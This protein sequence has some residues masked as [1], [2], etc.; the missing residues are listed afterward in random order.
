MSLEQFAT[1]PARSRRVVGLCLLAVRT[2]PID[3]A[4]VVLITDGGHRGYLAGAGGLSAGLEE[5]LTRIGEG[6]AIDA[7]RHG[8]PIFVPDL[9]TADYQSRWP[10]FTVEALLFGVAA[11]F[12]FPLRIGAID[13][14]VFVCYR[15]TPGP[16][17]PEALEQSLRLSDTAA[18]L[19]LDMT[20]PLTD[21]AAAHRDRL[22]DPGYDDDHQV[23]GALNGEG[24]D[25]IGAEVHQ[26]SG[27][28]MVQLGVPIDAALARLRAYA[29]AHDRPLVEVARRVI[30]HQLKFE[31]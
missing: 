16:L 29:F 8:V 13:L 25:F 6:P 28:L 30:A 20:A 12:A 31:R 18:Y 11:V 15:T 3:G 9:A 23:N 27:M 24:A 14:G 4:A 22:A 10:V 17:P 19:A 5:L 7:A 1:D 2:L 21:E 26:A